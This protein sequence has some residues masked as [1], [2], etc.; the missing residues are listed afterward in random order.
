MNNI[1]D[2][3]NNIVE[4]YIYKQMISLQTKII[5]LHKVGSQLYDIGEIMKNTPQNNI[6]YSDFLTPEEAV[7]RNLKD[8]TIKECLDMQLD[9]IKVK[10]KYIKDKCNLISSLV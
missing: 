7:I 6:A 5:K 9:L 10:Q 3:D 4:E 1:K 8:F 2:K